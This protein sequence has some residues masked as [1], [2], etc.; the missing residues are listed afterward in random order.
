MQ[1]RDHP[2]LSATLGTARSVTSFH[3]G[4][5]GGG[6][7][8]YVQAS[9][10][11][12]EL[13]GM[14]VAHHLRQQLA[15]LEREGAL[16]GEVVVVPVANPLGLSQWLLHTAAGRFDLASGANFN[17][18]YP[19]LLESVW[20]RVEATL[21]GDAAANVQRIRAALGEAV[22]A[23][24]VVSELASLRRTLLA[25]SCDA[26]VVL[27]LHCDTEAVMHLYTAPELWPQVEP[28]A[29]CL[30]AQASLLCEE[31]GDDPFDEACSQIWRRL[32]ER[33]GPSRPVP[34]A[35]T[36]VTVELRGNADIAHPE[37][38]ADAAALLAYLAHRGMVRDASAGAAAGTAPALPPLLQPA[39]PLAGSL[40]LVAPSSGVVVWL[41]HPGSWLSAGEPMAELV[42][43]VSGTVTVLSSPTEGL[44]YARISHRFAH[45]GMS[46]AKVAGREARRSGK[47]LSD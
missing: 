21:D 32:A 38:R 7:K 29:R 10:H 34:A 2:L 35:C 40:P 23:L 27:D 5:A 18:H 1:R 37:A 3:Y 13:P 31:S 6:P 26:D 12:D 25:L 4:P 15:A 9:L 20:Q 24:P 42:D 22:A 19:A 30:G 44:F 45:A 14:L 41:A 46:L 16:L 8:V 36:S 39:T 47:L 11:A 17:R 28:L 43:P 33:A